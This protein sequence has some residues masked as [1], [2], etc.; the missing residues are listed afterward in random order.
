[1]VADR[2]RVLVSL[3]DEAQE[4]QRLQGEDA[5]STGSRLGIEVEVDYCRTDL[6]VQVHHISAALRRPS[7]SRPGAV[8]LQPVAVAGLEETAR[9]A[10]E[11]GVNWVSLDPAVYLDRLR[12]EFPERAAAVVTVDNQEMG[13]LQGRMFQALLPRGGKV[14]YLE[15]PSFSPSTIRRREGVQERLRGSGVKIV[16]T[17]TGDWS[18]AGGLRALSFWL[19]LSELKVRPDLIGAQNDLMAVGARK[20]IQAIQPAWLDVLFTGC[21]GL[22]EGGQRLVRERVLAATVVQPPA[23]GPAVEQA[24]R[25][26][27][28]EPVAPLTFL[29]PSTFP[30][31]EQLERPSRP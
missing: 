25:A 3:L 9:A 27:R 17:L 29:P 8:V 13:R 2:Q 7:G 6:S 10:L 26:L 5:R 31:L 11:G 19:R 4:Y 12:R 20:A 18:E 14:V 23:A 22:P 28:G 1:V 21:D 30:P 15:G 16:K 24:A